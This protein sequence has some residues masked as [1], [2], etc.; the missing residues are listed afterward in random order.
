MEEAVCKKDFKP[1]TLID[2]TE[3]ANCN[4]P[5]VFHYQKPKYFGN[6]LALNHIVGLTMHSLDSC[7]PM[8][9]ST[10]AIHV[11][12]SSMNSK[13]KFVFLGVY[14]K[15]SINEDAS[16]RLTYPVSDSKGTRVVVDS[17][18]VSSTMHW[19]MYEASTPGKF[20]KQAEERMTKQMEDVLLKDVVKKMER[21]D[22]DK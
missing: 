21:L 22:E 12:V 10:K 3:V 14:Y 4:Y 19:K 2:S 13:S 11:Y 20:R 16:Y 17:G 1:S 15:T 18:T 6:S 5:V 9:D 7:P 8:P